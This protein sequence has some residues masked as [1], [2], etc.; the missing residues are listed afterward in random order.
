[1]K[2]DHNKITY[3]LGTVGRDMVYSLVSMYLM[4]YLT[5]VL[6]LDNSVLWWITLII[7]AARIFDA[8]NDP[9]MGVIVDNT[10]TRF[11]KFKPW[12]TIGAVLSGIMTV[13]LFTDMKLSGAAYIIVFGVIYVL[14][15]ITYTMHDISYWSMLPALSQDQHV[16]EKTGSVARI[17]A[18][19]GMFLVV[20]LIVPITEALGNVFGSLQKG[21]FVLAVIVTVIMHHCFWSKGAPACPG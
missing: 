19:V 12:I 7:L 4:F 2:K 6:Q 13:L 21:Y 16:R 9:F 10:H 8:L 5:D 3:G 20:S 1:M 11:G 17:C 15:G 14:W 18:S